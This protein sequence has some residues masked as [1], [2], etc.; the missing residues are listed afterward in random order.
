MHSSI[1]P[2]WCRSNAHLSQLASP[3]GSQPRLQRRWPE[4]L[5]PGLAGWLP[6]VAGG[7]AE[8][9]TGPSPST[10]CAILGRQLKR[11]TPKGSLGRYVTKFEPHKSLKLIISGNLTFDDKVAVHRAALRK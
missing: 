7:Q 4:P 10:P 3:G 9:R 2:P 1:A 8:K 11:W 5:Q 6:W